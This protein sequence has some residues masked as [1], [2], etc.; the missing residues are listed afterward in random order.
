MLKTCFVLFIRSKPS[1]KP[2]LCDMPST[3]HGSGLQAEFYMDP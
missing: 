1:Q 2:D 3:K